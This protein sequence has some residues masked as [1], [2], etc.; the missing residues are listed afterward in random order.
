LPHPGVKHT[1]SK[2]GAATPTGDQLLNAVVSAAIDGTGKENV[3]PNVPLRRPNARLLSA[4]VTTPPPGLYQMRPLGAHN[5]MPGQEKPQYSKAASFSVPPSMQPPNSVPI[6]RS[7]VPKYEQT[8][9]A[10]TPI[11][12]EDVQNLADDLWRCENAMKEAGIPIDHTN[13]LMQYLPNKDMAYVEYPT[14]AAVAPPMMQ[15]QQPLPPPT[16]QQPPPHSMQQW[17][18]QSYHQTNVLPPMAAALAPSPSLYARR[19]P[20]RPLPKTYTYPAAFR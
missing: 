7:D 13:T 15:Q 20:T 3:P 12:K 1:D 18:L 16:Q 14:F 9:V 5:S 19:E 17:Q 6:P 2:H 11:T 8:G 10:R 4:T